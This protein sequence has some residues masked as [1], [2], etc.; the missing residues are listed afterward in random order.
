MATSYCGTQGGTHSIHDGVWSDGTS[1]CE[2]KNLHEPE[3][4]YT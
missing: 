2:P 3:K 1:Y 4:F